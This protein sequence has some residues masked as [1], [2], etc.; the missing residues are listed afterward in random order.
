MTPCRRRLHGQDVKFMAYK[1]LDALLVD[2]HCHLQT[3]P[4]LPDL[5]PFLKEAEDAGIGAFLCCASV[6]EDWGDVLKLSKRH[7]EIIPFFGL[8]P[9]YIRT[10]TPGWLESL[11]ALLDRIP[12]AGIGEVGLDGLAFRNTL[13]DQER[14]FIAQL[15]LAREMKRPLSIHCRKAWGRMMEILKKEG[16]PH[17]AAF[18]AWSGSLEMAVEV[19]KLGA[20]IGFAGS[21]TKSANQKVRKSARGVSP[22]RLLVETDAPDIPPEGAG[23]FT[24]PSDMRLTFAALARI[25]EMPESALAR[26][27][28]ENSRNF[29]SALPGVPF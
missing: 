14:V 21:I 26:Q 29:L 23:D 11:A 9:F 12:C 7:P 13:E 16:I 15:R 2:T 27:L 10:R 8:H 24:K 28:L 1:N 6:E 3:A 19:E 18:H 5:T 22:D 20:Y 25:R 4:F 17:G